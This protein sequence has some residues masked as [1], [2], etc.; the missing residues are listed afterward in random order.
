MTLHSPEGY[1]QAKDTRHS[2]QPLS[3]HRKEL[4]DLLLTLDDCAPSKGLAQNTTLLAEKPGQASQRIPAQSS[5]IAGNI[6]RF[7]ENG[8]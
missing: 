6:E 3:R 8:N 2:W 5:P 7:V 1:H 4:H